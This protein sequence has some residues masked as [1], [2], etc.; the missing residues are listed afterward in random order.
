MTD[1][2]YCRVHHGL[3][4]LPFR[5]I[6]SGEQVQYLAKATRNPQEVK[7][8][9]VDFVD[10]SGNPTMTNGVRCHKDWVTRIGEPTPYN[11]LNSHICDCPIEGESK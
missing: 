6:E 2:Y 7:I 1:K 11:Y 9:T 5:K 10:V 3:K 8:G 4:R